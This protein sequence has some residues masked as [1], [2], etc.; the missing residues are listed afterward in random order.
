VAAR[1][2][3][4]EACF[5]NFQAAD[6]AGEVTFIVTIMAK[7]WP[8]KAQASYA[9]LCIPKTLSSGVVMVLLNALL[10]E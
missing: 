9:F 8:G 2:F 5:V 7:G 4:G 3:V 6:A 1:I 10:I